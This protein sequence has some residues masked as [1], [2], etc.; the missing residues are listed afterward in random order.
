MS[1]DWEPAA[2]YFQINRQYGNAQASNRVQKPK[3]TKFVQQ[4]AEG[5]VHVVS[6]NS[7]FFF[8]ASDLKILHS[9]LMNSEDVCIFSHHSIPFRTIGTA[10]TWYNHSWS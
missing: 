9:S 6:F 4:A 2:A 1:P 3:E 10:A 8:F 7:F 5:N